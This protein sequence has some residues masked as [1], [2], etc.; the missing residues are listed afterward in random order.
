MDSRNLNRVRK[1][2][3]DY[4]SRQRAQSNFGWLSAVSKE[5]RWRISHPFN[6][7]VG[8]DGIAD[9]FWRPLCRSLPDFE[10]R[11]D[12]FLVG[13]FAGK[14]WAA[15]TG[16]I[17]GTFESNWL[18]IPATNKPLFLRFGEILEI[19][20]DEIISGHIILDII[21]V[22]RQAGVNLVPRSLGAEVLAPAPTTHDGIRLEASS[23]AEAQKSLDLVEAMIA[24]LMDYDGKSINSMHQQDFWDPGM[25]WY[26][27]GGIGTTKGLSGFQNHHQ[28]P[29]LNFVPDRVGGNHVARIADGN[30]VASGGWPSI[31]A[32]TSGA[33][34]ISTAL[35]AHIPVTMRVMDFWRLEGDLLKENWV[36]I[37]IPDV[38]RQCGIDFFEKLNAKTT[39]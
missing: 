5:S 21:D 38:F 23:D 35:P 15:S 6:D 29:F 13:S 10:R 11:N 33:P 16:Y 12:I 24:G 1:T 25:L 34:W 14:N 28:I 7:L 3:W 27:P 22:A 36:F 9:K 26:G 2:G 20:N 39:A 19:V 18:S 8:R 17:I 30:Y 4:A 31:H 37:D 32:T